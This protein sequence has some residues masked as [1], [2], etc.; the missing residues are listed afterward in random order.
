MHT[1]CFFTKPNSK[2]S[3]E[4]ISVDRNRIARVDIRSIWGFKHLKKIIMSTSDTFKDLRVRW[5]NLKGPI[6]H[7]SGAH[8][9]AVG[10]PIEI[11]A[12]ELTMQMQHSF[13]Q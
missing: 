8:F 11:D 4:L 7:V 12:D 6:F 2:W 3:K 5:K 9:F 1:K 13:R 10:G